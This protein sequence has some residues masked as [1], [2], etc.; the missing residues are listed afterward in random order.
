MVLC[1]CL[2]LLL[3]LVLKL[4]HVWL[5]DRRQQGLVGLVAVRAIDGRGV[6]A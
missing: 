3:L 1:L 6:F 2:L 4:A 5:L